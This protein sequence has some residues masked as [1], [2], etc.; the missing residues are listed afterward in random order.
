MAKSHHLCTQAL[1]CC[2]SSVL[3]PWPNATADGRHQRGD[4]TSMSF[5][6][7]KRSVYSAVQMKVSRKEMHKAEGGGG[8]VVAGW[9]IYGRKERIREACFCSPHTPQLTYCHLAPGRMNSF[10]VRLLLISHPWLLLSYCKRIKNM[11][12]SGGGENEMY[13][14]YCMDMQIWMCKGLCSAQIYIPRVVYEH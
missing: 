7:V 6:M 14:M 2:T 1:S 4:V 5:E 3:L 11:K 9:G 8:G 13:K 10:S 12:G